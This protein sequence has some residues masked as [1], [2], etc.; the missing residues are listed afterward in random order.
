MLY[1]LPSQVFVH[2]CRGETH[3]LPPPLHFLLLKLLFLQH[4]CP[5]GSLQVLPFA[6]ALVGEVAYLQALL[7]LVAARI[8]LPA[9]ST[10]DAHTYIGIQMLQYNTNLHTNTLLNENCESYQP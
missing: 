9:A 8:L 6:C 4:L 5:G 7:A 10:A 2:T 3:I 1:F